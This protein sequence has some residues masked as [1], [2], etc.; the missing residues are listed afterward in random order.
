VLV[1]EPAHAAPRRG[2]PVFVVPFERARRFVEA[3]GALAIEHPAPAAMESGFEVQLRAK[4]DPLSMLHAA[5]VYVRAS[6][7]AG[8]HW[9]TVPPSET[10][11]A[12]M[13]RGREISYYVEALDAA[14]NV[15]E[16][17]GSADQPLVATRPAEKQVAPPS[18]EPVAKR[19][20]PPPVKTSAAAPARSSLVLAPTPP[21]RRPLRTASLATLLA[22]PPLL[23]LGIGLNVAANNEYDSLQRTCAPNCRDTTTLDV[24]RGFSI[25]FYT[26]AAASAVTSLVLF[27]VDRFQH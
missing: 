25:T 4:S 6:D 11:Y 13:V 8:A 17:F 18:N 14:G 12:A 2:S 20:V 22:V 1:L 3:N 16:R 19:P 7:E 15:L 5:R 10:R 27:L 21:P 24:E 23:A 9:A 26:L